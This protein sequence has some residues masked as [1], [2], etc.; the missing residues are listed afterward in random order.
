MVGLTKSDGRRKG[1]GVGCRRHVVPVDVP[2]LRCSGV[3]WLTEVCDF[4]GRWAEDLPGHWV[5]VYVPWLRC[6][7]RGPHMAGAVWYCTGS[8][9]TREFYPVLKGNPIL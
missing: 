3:L 7:L 4:W 6:A 2:W 5:D 9:S 8:R 1:R